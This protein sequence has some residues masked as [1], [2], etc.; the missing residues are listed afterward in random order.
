MDLNENSTKII[1]GVFALVTVIVGS[2][3][4]SKK[5]NKKR[6]SRNM[7]S[8]IKIEGDKNKIIGGDDNST[9]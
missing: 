3:W 5:K 2:A 1:L 9:N 8:N 6:S 7:V 4:V